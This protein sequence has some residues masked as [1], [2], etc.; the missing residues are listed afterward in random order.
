MRSGVFRG[1]L[2]AQ[3]NADVPA[4][5]V[6]ATLHFCR[7]GRTE[8]RPWNQ[9]AFGE[10]L[11]PYILNGTVKAGEVRSLLART[12]G[13]EDPAA[14]LSEVRHFCGA[15]GLHLAEFLY[16]A[17][18]RE[19][20]YTAAY[21]CL[22]QMP[23]A[24]AFLPYYLFARRHMKLDRLPEALRWVAGELEQGADLSLE[25][26]I[27][28][29]D[30]AAVI[31]Y[32]GLDRVAFHRNILEALARWPAANMQTRMRALWQ[33]GFP[34]LAGGGRVLARVMDLLPE[35]LRRQ[36]DPDA[37]EAPASVKGWETLLNLTTLN[38][39]SETQYALEPGGL[40]PD[41]PVA[42]DAAG[43]DTYRLRVMTEGYW[44][45]ADEQAIHRSFLDAFKAANARFGQ[46]FT[47]VYPVAA[48]HVFD[49]RESGLCPLP[50]LSY[51]TL[52]AP[53]Q[54]F[55]NFKEA[56]LPG[57]FK[58][59][60]EGFSGWEQQLAGDLAPD[61]SPDEIERVYRALR[62]TYVEDRRTKYDQQAVDEA[63]LPESFILVALQ[64]P[65]DT[66][67]SLS[68]IDTGTWLNALAAKFR[69]TDTSIVIKAH[70][71]DKSTVTQRRLEALR[72]SGAR[73]FLS[74]APIHDLLKSAE[75]L[76]TVNSGVG[77]EALLHMTPVIA[78]GASDYTQV[79]W[80][81]STLDELGLAFAAVQ[82]G[83]ADEDWQRRVKA[84]LYSYTERRSFRL[85][86]FPASFDETVAALKAGA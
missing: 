20:D 16:H 62:K 24:N 9:S 6:F 60:R 32:A 47:H 15:K 39:L 40:L 13:A 37:F 77:I 57:L 54:R 19:Q 44:R 48:T 50:T 3:A 7:H 22:A 83:A 10:W 36:I 78:L 18:L 85:D 73:V 41:E 42:L 26:L 43:P 23:M 25:H 76:V 35:A 66:V 56:A 79:S 2:Y 38:A 70:P 67:M 64:V 86:R 51:H 1:D 17:H 81:V 29:R 53:E 27:A 52:S 84:F 33:I 65:D 28:A 59:D 45:H 55:L 21:S 72:D 61:A 63:P 14:V 11:T 75:A 31:G 30:M 80:P 69:D 46:Q 71:L 58:F 68:R 74:K 34:V 12:G 49:Q 4:N 8:Q 82:S 5:P